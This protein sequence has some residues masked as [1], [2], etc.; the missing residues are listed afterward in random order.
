MSHRAAIGVSVHSGWGA[1]VAVSEKEEILDR[2][3]I[4]VADPATPGA[5]QP[6]HFVESFQL[7]DAESH[8][9]KCSAASTRLALAGIQE[10]IR[11][12]QD[13]DYHVENAVILLNASRPLPSL[14]R[15][16][17][18]HPLI[19]TAE[20]EFFRRIF[21]EAFRQLNINVAGI[22]ERE[23]EERA[24]VSFGKS[25]PAFQKRIDGMGRIVGPPWTNDHKNAALAAAIVLRSGRESHPAKAGRG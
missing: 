3:R 23:L 1:L 6:Y 15:I 13:I 2:R 12:L 20:G 5:K 11:R 7:G 17:A 16:L 25:A 22:P 14:E 24:R 18:A 21:R 10:S 4:I 8:L 19:H 9:T